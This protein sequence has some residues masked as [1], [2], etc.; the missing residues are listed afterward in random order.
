[1]TCTDEVAVE[2]LTIEEP[3]VELSPSRPRRVLLATAELSPLCRVG[4]LADATA[5]LVVALRRAGVHVDVVGPD[6]DGTPGLVV[7]RT[8]QLDVPPWAGPATARFGRVAGFG[9]VIVLRTRDIRRSHPYNHPLTGEG[10][11]D[12][13]RRFLGF[14]A[15]VAALADRLAPDVVHLHYWHAAAAAAWTPGGVPVVLTIHNLAYQG[16]A[17]LPW[18]ER[19]GER[20]HH[21]AHHGACNPLAGAIALADRVVAVSPT[22]AAETRR[23]PTGAGLEDLLRARGR[24]YLGIRNGIDLDRWDPTTDPHLPAPFSWDAPAGKAAS[25]AA[26]LQAA[27]LAANADE[28]VIGMVCRFVEQKGV[29]TALALAAQ[30]RG[31]GARLVLMGRGEPDLE[32]AAAAAWAS[33]PMRIGYLRDTSEGLAHLVM[34]GSD[35]LLVPSRFEPCGLTPMEAMRYGTIP[36]VS[37]VGGLRDSVIDASGNEATGNGFVAPAGDV[38][39]MSLALSRAVRAWSDP[40][41]RTAIRRAGMTADWSWRGPAAAYAEVYDEVV[42]DGCSART[43]ASFAPATARTSSTISAGAFDGAPAS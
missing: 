14:S 24:D 38:V 41:R 6:H 29:D 21:F 36:V 1:M 37:P 33:D 32:A 15:G 9:E 3:V 8:E 18:L 7:D 12:N 34:A 23:T 22:Y 43:R 16:L 35:L 10:W 25:R 5:G 17:P 4:G 39:G 11:G 26:L 13:D 27:G 28:P 40:V 20:A 31:V 30:L 2:Y 19:M 42:G